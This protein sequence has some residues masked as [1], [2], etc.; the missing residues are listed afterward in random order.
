MKQL[1]FALGLLPMIFLAWPSA[2]TGLYDCGAT[3][4]ANWKTTAQ[5]E[6]KMKADGWTVRHV[7]EDGGCYEAYGTS[8]EGKRGGSLFPSG[9]P[10]IDAGSRGAA[11]FCSAKNSERRL[12]R[13]HS[14][15]DE[16]IHIGFGSAEGQDETRQ[17]FS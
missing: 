14:S 13:A 4:R 17:H 12:G 9:H 8:P 15:F 6:D 11:R 10:G 1:G 3:D 5:L 7:K 16:L 2:A